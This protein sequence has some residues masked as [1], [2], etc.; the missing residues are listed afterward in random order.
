MLRTFGEQHTAAMSRSLQKCPC[1]APCPLGETLCRVLKA[2]LRLANREE[3]CWSAHIY[4]AS[5]GMR[6]EDMF[7]QKM[8]SASKIPMQDFLGDLRYEGYKP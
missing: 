1:T 8:L 2:D 6:Y 3:C 7:K 5:S 4:T